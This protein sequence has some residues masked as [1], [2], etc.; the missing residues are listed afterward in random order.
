MIRDQVVGDYGVTDGT[1]FV[2][3]RDAEAVEDIVR[4]HGLLV[5]DL[6]A[7]A[8]MVRVSVEDGQDVFVVMGR[9]RQ[10]PRVSNVE[11]NTTFDRLTPY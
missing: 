1:F 9:V 2:F 11:L 6:F 5:E 4:E 7:N 10:D 8:N 3:F